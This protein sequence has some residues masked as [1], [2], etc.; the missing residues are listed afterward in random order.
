VKRI[1]LQIRE[2]RPEKVAI[3]VTAFSFGIAGE[4]F[5]ST[6]KRRGTCNT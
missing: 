5:G 2:Y 3:G 1:G 6:L 4:L